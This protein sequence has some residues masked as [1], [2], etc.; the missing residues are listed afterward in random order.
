MSLSAQAAQLARI[1]NLRPPPPE[2][3]VRIY[4]F[5]GPWPWWR[6]LCVDC[7]ERMLTETARGLR[8]WTVKQDNPAPHSLRCEG[9]GCAG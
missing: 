8:L 9:C 6:W 3:K 4:Q 7:K 5:D 2:F 1:A